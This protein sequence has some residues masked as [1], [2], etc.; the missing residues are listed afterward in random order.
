VAIDRALMK[1]REQRWATGREMA[2]VI[3]MA[4]TPRG[5]SSGTGTQAGSPAAG[6]AGP[7]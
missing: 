7:R 5:V 3:G 4:W 1:D 6:P 2:E